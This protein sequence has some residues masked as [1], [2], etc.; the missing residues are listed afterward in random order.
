MLLS[1][2]LQHLFD[3]Q[4]ASGT[5]ASFLAKESACLVLWVGFGF[6]LWA[7]TAVGCKPEP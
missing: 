6:S 3:P 1:R 2:F 5:K 7:A 4:R